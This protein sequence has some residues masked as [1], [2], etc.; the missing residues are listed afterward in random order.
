MNQVNARRPNRAWHR[1]LI[2]PVAILAGSL[3]LITLAGRTVNAQ[4]AAPSCTSCE[5]TRVECLIRADRFYSHCGF[6]D[7]VCERIHNI[8]TQS[9]SDQ[10]GYCSGSCDPGGVTRKHSFPPGCTDNGL[11]FLTSIESNGYVS[12]R[13]IDGDAPT[14]NDSIQVNFY[15]DQPWDYYHPENGFAGQAYASLRIPP[16]SGHGFSFVIPSQYRDGQVHTLYAYTWDPCYGMN[17][18]FSGSPQN[19]V[20]QP[21]NPIDDPHTFVRQLY[22]DLLRREPDQG[23]WDFWTGQITQCGTD[24]SC[25]NAQRANLV[26]AFLNSGEYV[27]WGAEPMLPWTSSGTLGYNDLYVTALYESLL[28]RPPDESGYNYWR[29]VLSGFGDPTPQNGYQALA[30]AFIQSGEYRNRFQ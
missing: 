2:A 21:G 3:T 24:T 1:I 7:W 11:G 16:G 17:H 19:F 20:L 8:Q 29:D 9:C 6:G 5:E 4:T 13:A 10:D 26:S 25:I 15:I 27:A 12:G 18:F 28:R 30:D 14:F 22:I 23:G